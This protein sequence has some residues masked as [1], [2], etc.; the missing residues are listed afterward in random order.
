[1]I[2]GGRK[3]DNDKHTRDKNG[4]M[5]VKSVLMFTNACFAVFHTS[6]VFDHLLQT[7]I[8]SCKAGH[9]ICHIGYWDIS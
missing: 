6:L 1:M 2:L 7:P 3:G 9:N 5:H 4:H 8:C